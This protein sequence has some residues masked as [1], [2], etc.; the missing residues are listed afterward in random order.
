MTE[1]RELLE[2]SENELI[3]HTTD[4][5]FHMLK[6]KMKNICSEYGKSRRLDDNKKVR[7]LISLQEFLRTMHSDKQDE[8]MIEEFE[9]ILLGKCKYFYDAL[10]NVIKMHI[11]I[12]SKT[13]VGSGDKVEVIYPTK[14]DYI[15][16]VLSTLGEVTFHNVKLY[17]SYFCSMDD[18]DMEKLLQ[19]KLKA[20]L[21]RYKTTAVE[22][23]FDAQGETPLTLAIL[24]SK[25]RESEEED[26]ARVP[27]EDTKSNFSTESAKN[28]Y[29]KKGR[30]DE[31]KDYENKENVDYENKE[32]VDPQKSKDYDD[33][34]N[35]EDGKDDK[36][37]VLN[38]S[39]YNYDKK[40]E[41][42]DEKFSDILSTFH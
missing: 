29:E 26:K 5:F 33:F 42:K 40:T 11:Y 16:S 2:L 25:V 8:K 13:R 23:F 24:N 37:V 35:P 22:H 38:D 32:N 28:K 18:V 41:R 20:I 17:Y 36:M 4:A 30:K 6:P 19:R 14:G 39:D 21:Q 34:F 9:S 10:K 7:A 12:R 31:D 1:Y 3:F 15:K 27:E